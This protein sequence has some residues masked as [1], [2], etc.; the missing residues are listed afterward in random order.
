MAFLLLLINYF[1]NHF[2][3]TEQ[4]TPRDQLGSIGSESNPLLSHKDDNISSWGS[5]DASVSENEEDTQAGV[6]QGGKQVKDDEYSRRICAIC[7]DAPKDCFFIPCGHCVACFG[8]AT[9]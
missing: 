3:R 8:C 7:F 6:E 4:D 5:S 9:R 1:M 2:R